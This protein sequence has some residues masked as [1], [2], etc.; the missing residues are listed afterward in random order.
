MV[1][2][3]SHSPL[4]SS[5]S[6][7]SVSSDDQK[8]SMSPKRNG[9]G[10]RS[11]QR[12]TRD[13]V[14]KDT[15]IRGSEADWYE[16]EDDRLSYEYY[17]YADR[18]YGG[19]GEEYDEGDEE[20]NEEQR[21][22]VEGG[23]NK[24][25]K[26]QNYQANSGG[27]S[28]S[29]GGSVVG[30]VIEDYEEYDGDELEDGV[31]LEQT[32]YWGDNGRMNVKGGGGGGGIGGGSGGSGGTGGTGGTE[33]SV[34]SVSSVSSGSPSKTG[35]SL[36]KSKSSGSTGDG[37]VGGHTMPTPSPNRRVS[38]AEDVWVKEIPRVD[39]SELSDLFY[40]EA[41]IDDMYQEAEEEVLSATIPMTVGSGVNAG[42]SFNSTV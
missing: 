4:K 38:F 2:V 40:S 30:G 19:G 24:S 9:R 17:Q 14:V 6:Y 34:S 32:V 23:R 20:D 22:V 5:S 10:T 35:S 21:E 33:T 13:V 15:V 25:Q 42:S 31:D 37:S 12:R 11:T 8:V 39:E 3:A 16:D 28:G 7:S 29:S 36:K 41:D 18:G 26:Q 1:V 27:S